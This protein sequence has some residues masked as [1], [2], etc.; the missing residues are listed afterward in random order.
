MLT[1]SVS[2]Y[3]NGPAAA[4]S[5]GLGAPIVKTPVSYGIGGYGEN[6]KYVHGSGNV[7]VTDLTLCVNWPGAKGTTFEATTDCDVETTTLGFPLCQYKVGQV[8]TLLSYS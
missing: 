5:N 1:S 6:A 8:T 7:A 2:W 4:A 3:S